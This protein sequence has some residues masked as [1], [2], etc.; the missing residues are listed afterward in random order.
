MKGNGMRLRILAGTT[1]LS[2]ALALAGT[3]VAPSAHRITLTAARD[4]TVTRA[5]P[6]TTGK[7]AGKSPAAGGVFAWY[8]T[9]THT[10]LNRRHRVTRMTFI[11]QSAADGAGTGE[12]RQ[13]GLNSCFTLDYNRAHPADSKIDRLGCANK[14]SQQIGFV[15]I[16]NSGDPDFVN[17]GLCWKAQADRK[18]ILLAACPENSVRGARKWVWTRREASRSGAL[19]ATL[20]SAVVPEAS[21]IITK[22]CINPPPGGYAVGFWCPFWS[23]VPAPKGSKLPPTIKMS[24]R[25]DVTQPMQSI[26]AA[27][28]LY[29]W[30]TVGRHAKE[31]RGCFAA[32]K[33][34]L[35]HWVLVTKDFPRSGHHKVIELRAFC[36]S[37]KRFPGRY[38]L[39]FTVTAMTKAG[40]IGAD[41]WY[42]PWNP[43]I[44][45]EEGI[46]TRKQS[47]SIRC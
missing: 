13:A 4:V 8:D 22:G 36:T 33:L 30:P 9:S 18:K 37:G 3:A 11:D 21:H 39:S 43:N 47:Q 10:L 20:A 46:P 42:D 45:S 15:V 2:A 32:S 40:K 29:K 27:I 16:S 28:W 31:Y 23:V 6:G 41:H 44:P 34:R 24:F 26:H 25:V 17:Y 5:E 38:Y 7:W 19:P 12:L 1:L 14:A 35:C